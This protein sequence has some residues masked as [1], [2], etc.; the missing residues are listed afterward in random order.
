M[1]NKY[2]FVEKYTVF[3]AMDEIIAQNYVFSLNISILTYS[4]IKSLL[5]KEGMRLIVYLFIFFILHFWTCA[6]TL[7]WPAESPFTD[8]YG[9]RWETN[10]APSGPSFNWVDIVGLGQEIM[11][12]EDETV[13]GPFSIGIDFP[14][15]WNQYDHIY[16]S[17]NGYLSFSS[18]IPITSGGNGFPLIPNALVPND[19]IA[20][21]LADMTGEGAN[22]SGQVWIYPDSLNNRCII[23]WIDW[24]YF[25]QQS[26]SYA[27]ANSFQVILDGNDSSIVFQYLSMNGS[28]DPAYD[29]VTYPFVVGIENQ[30][31]NM[32]LMP[33]GL[34]I[35]ATIRP[36]DSTAIRFVRPSSPKIPIIDLAIDWAENPRSAAIFLPWSPPSSSAWRPGHQLRAQISNVG[37][38]A[39][40]D[41]F[42][43]RTWVKDSTGH[44]IFSR[45]KAFPGIS[46]DGERFFVHYDHFQAPHAGTFTQQTFLLNSST[47]GDLSRINDTMNV[48]LIVLDTTQSTHLLSYERT[49]AQSPLFLYEGTAAG[50]EIVPYGYPAYISALEYHLFLSSGATAN[51]GFL[52]RLYN[53]DSNSLTGTLLYE[54]QIP[55]SA[56]V[57]PSGWNRIDL[58]TP[59]RID[60]GS[61][62]VSW[63]QVD[64][65]LRL[66]TDRS[67]PLARRSYD[68]IGGEWRESLSRHKED[69]MIRAVVDHGEAIPTVGLGPSIEKPFSWQIYPSPAREW[70]YIEIE[71]S[72]RLPVRLRLV[73]AA[74]I[75]VR[76]DVVSAQHIVSQRWELEN[77]A[78]GVYVVELLVGGVRS[79][80]KVVIW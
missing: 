78:V 58:P 60:S 70:L 55:L 79:V 50:I 66:L 62:F 13:L 56:V 14:F 22:N 67:L 46:A 18:D 10:S 21:F 3:I 49:T 38:E 29:Q 40:S 76:E 42:E 65:G 48:E 1:D 15:Y 59:V 73:N 33:T 53:T 77:L 37:I 12:L 2:D 61:L 43:V 57:L 23:S 54:E 28:W 39:I 5:M 64:P 51:T 6:Q 75:V 7:P 63:E 44:V 74:G 52:A 19:V 17:A 45:T 80:R 72:D 35:D 36:V 34:P 47:Y 71:L 30:V 11:N 25:S 31:G 24:P 16:I 8:S 32:G 9:Y 20:P 68:F 69:L 4:K 26:P 41:S 27:G